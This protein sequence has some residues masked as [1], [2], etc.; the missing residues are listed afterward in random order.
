M[1]TATFSPPIGPSFE[2]PLDVQWEVEMTEFVKPYVQSIPKSPFGLQR[3]E[4][5]W[6]ILTED[7]A[8]AIR[9]FF[10]RRCGPRDPFWWTPARGVPSP[11]DAGPDLSTVAGGALAQRTY[12]VKFTWYEI[13]TA[14]ETLASPS[15]SITVPANYLLRATVPTWPS[16]VSAWRIYIGTVNG[17]EAL[18]GYEEDPEWN[19]ISSGI[20]EPGPA[21]PVANTLKIPLKWRLDGGLSERLLRPGRYSISA[22][23][24]EY[25]G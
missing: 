10:H 24:V 13:A 14:K 8:D 11:A 6:R 9:S 15:T 22:R 7:Q 2:L 21:I 1:T 19:E 17:S 25:L 18:Q 3:Y 5:E 20:I 4:L 16:R 23:F 12:Y